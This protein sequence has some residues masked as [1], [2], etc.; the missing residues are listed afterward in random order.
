MTSTMTSAALTDAL[1]A[2]GL[3]RADVEPAPGPADER[4]W[5]VSAVLGA[6]GWLAGIFALF[7]VGVLFEPDTPAEFAVAG[8][9]MLAAAFGLYVADRGTAF[10]DQL[11]LALSIAG[12]CALAWA[13]AA[14]TESAAA[15]AGW[16]A[17]MQVALLVVMPNRLARVLA[18]LFAC[19][20]W[21]LAVRLGLWDEASLGGARA[22]VPLGLALASWLLIW[23]PLVGAAHALIAHEARWMAGRWCRIVRPGQTGLLMALSIATWVSEPFGSLVFWAPPG[24]T[25]VNWLVVWPLLGAATALLAALCAYRLRNRALVGLAIAG[26]LLHVMQ[27][28]YLLGTTLVMKSMIMLGVGALLLVGAWVLER[29]PRKEPAQ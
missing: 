21:A 22:E 19:I 5:Y 24:E 12:Q 16:V 23:A 14:A 15:T 29:R 26:A 10:F 8:V 18:G 1:V 13:A 28:Y 17:A 27:F 9:V 20:A 25:Y 3:L 11:A 6:A 4:P 2:R 7:F